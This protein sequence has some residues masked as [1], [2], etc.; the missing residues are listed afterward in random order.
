MKSFFSNKWFIFT[1][2]ALLVSSLLSFAILLFSTDYSKI[3]YINAFIFGGFMSFMFGWLLF[4]SGL[5]L[6][7]IAVYGV[8]QFWVGFFGKKMKESYIDYHLNKT[9]FSAFIY[10]PFWIVG[11]I[12]VIVPWSLFYIL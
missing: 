4:V 1:I 2:I 12:Y 11:I 3:G 10:V 9:S 5:G 8:K 6:F 7:D